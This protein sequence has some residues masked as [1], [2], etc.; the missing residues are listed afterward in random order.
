MLFPSTSYNRIFA[1]A[2]E[3]KKQKTSPRKYCMGFIKRLGK[4]PRDNKAKQLIV[5]CVVF[6][7]FTSNQ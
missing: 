7:F 1:R 3:R 2:T 4:V 6:L 5:N